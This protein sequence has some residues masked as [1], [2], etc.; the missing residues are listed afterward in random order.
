MENLVILN[1][2]LTVFFVYLLLSVIVSA[3]N[4]FGTNLFNSRG[5]LL[6]QSLE[7]LFTSSDWKNAMTSITNS[8]F[9]TSIRKKPDAFPDHIPAKNFSL[10]LLELIK[11][12]QKQDVVETDL[13]KL[14][15]ACP[16]LTQDA[17]KTLLTLVDKAGGDLDTFRKEVEALY[18][19]LMTR[20]SLWYKR[21]VQY[22][23]LVLG[24]VIAAV[25]NVDT[26]DM[27]KTLS[28]NPAAAKTGA[29]M[30][31]QSMSRMSLTNGSITVTNANKDTSFVVSLVVPGL[32]STRLAAVTS[33]SSAKKA[34]GTILKP[35][36][37]LRSTRI[38]IT[39]MNN[40]LQSTGLQFTWSSFK[41]GPDDCAAWFYKIVGILLTA[42]AVSL[43][44]PFWF[45]MVNSL[46][47]LRNAGKEK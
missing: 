25:M 9:I 16:A 43:G 29:D 11:D 27:V 4:E 15:I 37:S 36:D 45:Q 3:L 10:A 32:D 5:K 46:L 28:R 31:A 6:K 20:T 14:I 40:S 8:G 12:P 13:K 41:P 19:D 22:I 23:V 33:D 39:D 24:L 42:L 35:A 2:A 21:N 34:P 7:S 38:I 18:E 30:V 26:I 44:A 1:V 17:E 47:A